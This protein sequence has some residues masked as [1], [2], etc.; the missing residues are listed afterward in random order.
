MLQPLSACPAA[1]VAR[2]S[3]C[4]Q[5]THRRFHSLSHASHRSL[6]RG[7]SSSSLRIIAPKAQHAAADMPGVVRLLSPTTA[8]SST[9]GMLDRIN[10]KMN[11]VAHDALFLDLA[12]VAVSPAAKG[13][14]DTPQ[15]RTPLRR[16]HSQSAQRFRGG[17]QLTHD[18]PS[19]SLAHHHHHHEREHSGRT[20]PASK[21]TI[22]DKPPVPPRWAVSLCP[23]RRV[24]DCC[25]HSSVF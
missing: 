7:Y 8:M 25:V 17:N 1:A 10:E 13:R 2:L 12:T 11:Q 20:T 14:L 23:A 19:H 24:F 15:H 3:N 6:P 16:N 9:A 4:H 22:E 5:L 21:V 18:F